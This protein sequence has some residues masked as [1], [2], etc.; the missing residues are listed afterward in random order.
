[1]AGY[2]GVHILGELVVA[3][4]L[5]F[6]GLCDGWSCGFWGSLLVH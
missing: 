1:M 2:G 6:G 4:V 5:F 3:S